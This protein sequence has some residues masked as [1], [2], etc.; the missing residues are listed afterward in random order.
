MVMENM[1]DDVCKEESDLYF[2]LMMH[3]MENEE[4]QE[5]AL[6][7]TG[8]PAE[9]VPDEEELYWMERVGNA[10]REEKRRERTGKIRSVSSKAA[11]V[12]IAFILA[13][14]LASV[15]VEAVWKQIQHWFLEWKDTFVGISNH[16]DA[17]E[18]QSEHDITDISFA[19][20]YLP[21][22]C[23]L[24]D[25]TVTVG[26]GDEKVV[27]YYRYD[28]YN[29]KEQIG[30]IEISPLSGNVYLDDED[31]VIEYPEIKGYHDVIYTEKV[32]TIMG[33]SELVRKLVAQNDICMI[34][35]HTTSEIKEAIT[36]E[37]E[38]KI[39]ENLKFLGQEKAENE[40]ERSS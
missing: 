20:G 14:A 6:E 38:I 18:D 27:M 16:I 37:D 12:L 32:Y 17:K 30:N 33:S 2:Y 9:S 31:A 11:A 34:S 13:G 15:P 3:R 29:G 23:Y 4:M 5:A 1:P 28:I 25:K 35:V 21:E 22:G 8:D 10:L 40:K 26:T 19:F 24:I 39:L 36:K 7:F